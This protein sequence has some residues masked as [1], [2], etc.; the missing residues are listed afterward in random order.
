MKHRLATAL[1]TLFVVL[2]PRLAVAGDGATIIMKSG[3][4]VSITNGYSQLV[5]GMRALKSSGVQ[6]YPVEIVIE[7]TSFFVNLGEV[8]LLCRDTCS[9]MTI[10]APRQTRDT[11]GAEKSVL[12]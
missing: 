2:A 1:V 6:N 8:A 3:V 4:V 10:T 12:R 5:T 9:S 11:R 7:G